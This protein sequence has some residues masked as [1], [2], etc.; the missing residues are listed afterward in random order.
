M[1]I[2]IVCESIHNKYVGF[3]GRVLIRLRHV[4]SAPTSSFITAGPNVINIMKTDVINNKWMAH[5]DLTVQGV[6]E[7]VSLEIF[8]LLWIIE[9]FICV[10]WFWYRCI[11]LP[12]L[13]VDF[14]W[15]KPRTMTDLRI[16]SKLPSFTRYLLIIHD[17]CR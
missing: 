12:P 14:A 15:L 10:D 2:L 13:N 6:R 5:Y 1:Q 7:H 3:I 16:K 9:A 4:I 11:L 8:F 17:V